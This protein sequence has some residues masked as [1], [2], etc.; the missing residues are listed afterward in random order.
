MKD[1]IHLLELLLNKVD[2][3]FKAFGFWKTLF[4]LVVF[5]IFLL[6]FI[7][8]EHKFLVEIFKI[9]CETVRTAVA[10]LCLVGAF[11]FICFFRRLV[12][13]PSD[14]CLCEPSFFNVHL[15]R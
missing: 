12:N 1:V 4:I 13:S 10:V 14:S 7:Y 8:L 2:K 5:L 15:M 11:F 9:A 3:W 6:V